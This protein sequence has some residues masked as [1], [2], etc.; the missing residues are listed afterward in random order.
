[1]SSNLFFFW[2][3]NIFCQ[4]VR[5]NIPDHVGLYTVWHSNVLSQIESSICMPALQMNFVLKHIYEYTMFIL[6]LNRPSSKF[7]AQ[8][9]ECV[10]MSFIKK[11][12]VCFKIDHVH[13][14]IMYHVSTCI[15][16]FFN[17]HIIVSYFYQIW[18]ITFK[19]V[20]YDRLLENTQADNVHIQ[21]YGI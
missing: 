6:K 10:T 15:N 13:V 17:L 20:V 9:F 2:S 8:E 3:Q 18:S 11:C 21:N 1:M 5:I 19:W 12:H 4:T 7:S 16:N 14:V